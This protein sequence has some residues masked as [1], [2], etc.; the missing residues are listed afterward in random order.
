MKN[1]Q[2]K[3]KVQFKYENIQKFSEEF[4]EKLENRK[5]DQELKNMELYKKWA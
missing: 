5:Y 4:D 1:K 2:A 3:D